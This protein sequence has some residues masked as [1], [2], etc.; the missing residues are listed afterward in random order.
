MHTAAKKRPH[1]GG[2]LQTQVS[3]R[4]LRTLV[5]VAVKQRQMQHIVLFAA[6][7]GVLRLMRV[8]VAVQRKQ[9]T[10]CLNIIR[11]AGRTPP[12]NYS[13]KLHKNKHPP[14]WQGV[15]RQ[16]QGQQCELLPLLL[17][18]EV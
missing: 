14:E 9:R 18:R 3:R 10:C 4:C 8:R 2:L 16:L 12:C 7:M 1:V 17:Y 6:H 5:A 15:I 11:S 13:T